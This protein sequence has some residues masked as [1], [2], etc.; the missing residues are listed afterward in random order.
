M[1][2][3]VVKTT[4]DEEQRQKD[5]AFLRFSPIERLDFARKV[6]ERM[7]RSDVNYSFSGQV[8]KVQKS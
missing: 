3:K 5:E 6:R 7:K 2:N 4:F 1:I 8:V